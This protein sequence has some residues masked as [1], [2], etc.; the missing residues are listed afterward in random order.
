MPRSGRPNIGDELREGVV[1]FRFLCISF[2]V[3]HV[4]VRAPSQLGGQQR[5]DR[6]RDELPLR[7]PS[8]FLAYWIT[9]TSRFTFAARRRLLAE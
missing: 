1:L 5:D 9:A 6:K 3:V 8:S 2:S 4:P 7:L